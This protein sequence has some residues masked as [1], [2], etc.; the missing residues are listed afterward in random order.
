MQHYMCN[1]Y[2]LKRFHKIDG[3]SHSFISVL[4]VHVNFLA[5]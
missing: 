1:S 5:C 2:L 4:L 3:S